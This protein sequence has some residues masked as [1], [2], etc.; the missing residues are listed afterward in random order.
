VSEYLVQYEPDGTILYGVVT[1]TSANFTWGQGANQVGKINLSSRETNITAVSSINLTSP[2]LLWNGAPIGGGTTVSTF[3]QLNTNILSNNPA[4]SNDLLLRASNAIVMT[5]PLGAT[6]IS[7]GDTLEITGTTGATNIYTQ[8]LTSLNTL[9]QLTASNMNL[10][11][12][13]NITATSLSSINFYSPAL[14]WNGAPIGGG[15]GPTVST[16][17]QLFTSSIQTNTI[18]GAA[19]PPVQTQLSTFTTLFTTTLSNNPVSPNLTIDCAG[20]LTFETIDASINAQSNI[21]LY[22]LN[23]DIDLQAG[24]S[25]NFLTLNSN[26]FI[27]ATTETIPP[28]TDVLGVYIRAESNIVIG[29]DEILQLTALSSINI[30]T[31]TINITNPQTAIYASTLGVFTD[32]T[33]N[34]FSS[35]CYFQQTEYGSQLVLEKDY[36]QLWGISSITLQSDVKVDIFSP[37]T[38]CQGDIRALTFNGAPL[39]A[40]GGG[41]WV[42]TATSDLNM[43]GYNITTAASSNLAITGDNNL[44]LTATSGNVILAVSTAVKLSYPTLSISGNL[45]LNSNAQLTYAAQYSGYDIGHECKIPLTQYGKVSLTIEEENSVIGGDYDLPCPFDGGEFSVVLQ[46]QNTSPIGPGEFINWTALAVDSNTFQ[47][48]AIGSNITTPY[49]LSFYYIAVG[50]YPRGVPT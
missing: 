6:G 3:T 34:F 1:P 49:T 15:G 26:I 5:T 46:L 20:E 31:S 44:T 10:T 32:A 35:F 47:I 17:Q 24:N 50:E 36:S 9:V 21:T 45:T 48:N 30:T 2:S 11:G 16:F 12:Q 27:Y 38:I 37:S 23:T 28:P 41:S 4:V 25:I 33:V 19:Y 40:G 29:A 18:N 14:L 13:S 42:S 8:N 43:N 7:L 22:T 39:P